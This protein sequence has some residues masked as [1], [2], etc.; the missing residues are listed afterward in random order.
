MN[1]SKSKEQSR[2]T[3]SPTG[4][5]FFIISLVHH[6]L[7]LLSASH[8]SRSAAATPQ[9]FIDADLK[10]L[11]PIDTYNKIRTIVDERALLMHQVCFIFIHSILSLHLFDF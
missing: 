3:P 6:H 11:L 2:T 10:N 4:S 1:T 7:H 9:F 8:P 5:S